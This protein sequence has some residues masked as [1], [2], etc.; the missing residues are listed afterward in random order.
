MPSGGTCLLVKLSIKASWWLG[1]CPLWGVASWFLLCAEISPPPSWWEST[2]LTVFRNKMQHLVVIQDR[3]L[4]S[5]TFLPE[6]THWPPAPP[7][8]CLPHPFLLSE[9]PSGTTRSRG[10]IFQFGF[11]PH[12]VSPASLPVTVSGARQHPGRRGSQSWTVKM[13]K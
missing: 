11:S 6:T 2:M 3:S 10:R 1:G 12:C 13:S 8:C 4:L 9:S 7:I 5:P